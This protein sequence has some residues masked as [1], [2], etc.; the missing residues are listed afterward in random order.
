M[1]LRFGVNLYDKDGDVYKHAILLFIDENVIL[2]FDSLF[3]LEG[4]RDK[5]TNML[6]EIWDNL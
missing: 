2:K 1:D 6:P 4:F 3:E 5:I